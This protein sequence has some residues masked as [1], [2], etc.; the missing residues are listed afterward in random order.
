MGRAYKRRAFRR[1]G[2]DFLKHLAIWLVK[3]YKF[4]FAGVLPPACRFSPTCSEYA[5]EVY[6][7]FGFFVGSWKTGRRILKCHPWHPGGFDPV[8]KT[9]DY[10]NYSDTS[11]RSRGLFERTFEY[12]YFP[13]GNLGPEGNSDQ[14]PAS[15]AGAGRKYLSS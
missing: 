1:L 3:L 7:R 13:Q 8:I 11:W 2:E 14:M 4:I 6:S 15:S 9:A 10:A 12:R 5:I